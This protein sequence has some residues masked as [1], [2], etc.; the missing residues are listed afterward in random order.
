[1]SGRETTLGARLRLGVVGSTDPRRNPLLRRTDVLRRRA[2]TA[3]VLALPRRPTTASP[4]S[5]AR[6]VSP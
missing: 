3:L 5:C 1:M 6:P 2:R 4:A